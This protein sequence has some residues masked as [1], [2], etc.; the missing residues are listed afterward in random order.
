MDKTNGT[1]RRQGGRAALTKRAFAARGFAAR[2]GKGARDATRGTQKRGAS[3][4]PAARLKRAALKL[5]PEQQ[6][7]DTEE[8]MKAHPKPATPK[9]TSD[10]AI[11]QVRAEWNAEH[12][13]KP[14][15]ALPER[16]TKREG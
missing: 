12:P 7:R 16:E 5:T 6:A 1:K 3:A 4:W 14:L 11:R 10:E 15:P 13:G 8:W 9:P 2:M